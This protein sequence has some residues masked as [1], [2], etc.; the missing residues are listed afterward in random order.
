[1]QDGGGESVRRDER[2]GGAVREEGVQSAAA[3][4]GDGLAE[5]ERL[6]DGSSERLAVGAG[7]D[8]IGGGDFGKGG[9]VRRVEDQRIVQSKIAGRLP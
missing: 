9:S 3:A 5:G 8:D 7:D 4:S 1:M 2:D 6:D